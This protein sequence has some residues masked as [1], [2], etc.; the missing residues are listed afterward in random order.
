MRGKSVFDADLILGD[1]VKLP[2]SFQIG[3]GANQHHLGELN[4]SY[5]MK[6]G[7]PF[8]G[9]EAGA[10]DRERAFQVVTVDFLLFSKEQAHPSR[11]IFCAL[12]IPFAPRRCQRSNGTKSQWGKD[13]FDRHAT[14]V[15]KIRLQWLVEAVENVYAAAGVAGVQ[16]FSKA[17]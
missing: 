6:N 5:V 10:G 11:H 14:G 17:V 2:E 8:P 15:N 13:A 3:R 12:I 4:G 9:A 1:A 7:G 16:D